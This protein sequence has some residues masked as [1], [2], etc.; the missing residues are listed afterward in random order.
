MD[1]FSDYHIIYLCFICAV[2]QF[3]MLDVHR[4]FGLISVHLL[5]IL[6]V[7]SSTIVRIFFCMESGNPRKNY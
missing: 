7:V 5:D 2:I 4:E 1:I 3:F 6:P